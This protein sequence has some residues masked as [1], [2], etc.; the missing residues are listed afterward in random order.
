MPRLFFAVETPDI[1][2]KE[3]VKLQ[4][5]IAAD[6]QKMIP[7]P[8]FKP[9]H[10]AN[11]HCTIRFLGNVGE[12]NVETIITAARTALSQM[13][14]HPFECNLSACGVFPNRRQARVMWIGLSPEDPF[15]TIQRAID[16]SLLAAGIPFEIEHSFHPHLTLFRFREPYRLPPDFDFPDL[17]SLSLLARISE[18]ALIESKTFAEGTEHIIRA[19]FELK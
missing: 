8:N 2:K 7:A 4:D 12:S 5:A 18:L 14:I 3:L 9:E 10:L 6:F 13:R 15:E 16:A 11:S 19:K 1:L 17:T